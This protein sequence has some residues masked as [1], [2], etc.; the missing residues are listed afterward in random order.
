[1]LLNWFD[2]RQA[3]E[4]GIS[5][6]DQF[7]ARDESTSGEVSHRRK[8]PHRKPADALRDFLQRAEREVRAVPLNFY[9]KAKLANAFRW[10][11]VERGVASATAAEVTQTL[12]MH[13]SMNR[14][15]AATGADAADASAVAVEQPVEQPDARQA[16]GLLAE[17][18]QHL[19]RGAYAEAIAAYQ[20]FLESKP[21]HV[22]ALNNLGAAHSKLGEYPQAEE[23][24]R[25]AIRLKPNDPDA[26]SNLGDVLRGLGNLTASED[27][28]RRALKLNPSHVEARALLGLTLFAFGRPADAKPHLQ[29]ALK[30]APRNV[31]ALVCTAKIA[32]AEGRFGDAEA[33]V[34]RILAIDPQS[35]TAWATLA[36]LRKMTSADSAWLERA[37]AIAALSVTP[38]EEADLRFAMGKYCD[39]VGDF[40]SAFRNYQRANELAK[41][42]ALPYDKEARTRFVDD[43]IRSHSRERLTDVSAAL[44]EARAST[45]PVLVVGMMR[46]GTSLVEQIIAS[47][48]AAAGAGEL[49]F[50][51]TLI[52]KHETTLRQGPL[53]L[54]L[55]LETARAYLRELSKHSSEALRV[56][57]KAPVNSDFLG[58]IHSVFPNARFLYMQRDPVDTCLSCY[59]QQFSAGVDYSMDLTDLAHYYH[60]HERLAAHWPSVLP[61]GTLLEIPYA[62]LVSDQANWTRK[63]LEFIGLDWDERCLNFQDTRRTV[64]TA[65]AW[66]VR[67]KIYKSSVSRWRNYEKFLGPLLELRESRFRGGPA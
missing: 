27:S 64:A 2:A 58:I 12:V 32:A 34:Q 9:K 49:G 63:I 44:E 60:S 41:S 55:R 14:L 28:L 1:M 39:D 15:A 23:Y 54:P 48:P 36:G 38:L 52:Q 7:A 18:D 10:R 57:D 50:W 3:A 42:N 20:A 8:S 24:F 67:Q 45:K 40:S 25:R 33:T 37:E 30:V 6:A 4:I 65:S 19:A 47:H 53:S 43:L 11:L 16:R 21:N 46:S 35:A 5:L 56:V 66:Q 26:H 51:S 59:F 22:R 17:G 61:P 13:L 29:R 62:E 31:A